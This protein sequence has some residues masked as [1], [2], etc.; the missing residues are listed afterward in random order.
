MIR[1]IRRKQWR[2]FFL[3]SHS[4]IRTTL[5]FLRLSSRST[6]RSLLLL[7]LIFPRHSSMLVW[8]VRF[9]PQSCPCQ[10]QPST[11]KAIFS[12]G[13]EKSGLPGSDKCLL[14]PFILASSIKL[15]SL[16]SVVLLPCPLTLDMSSERESRPKVVG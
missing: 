4:Q 13:H 12:L 16:N 1:L 10:K 7:P 6:C 11:N 8:G 14:Q 9:L 15:A 5:Q 2:G 3:S